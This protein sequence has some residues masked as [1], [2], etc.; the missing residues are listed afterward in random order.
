MVAGDADFP[1]TSLV[2]LG[3]G[4]LS[5]ILSIKPKPMPTVTYPTS[6]YNSFKF[7]EREKATPRWVNNP[8]GVRRRNIFNNSFEC[9]IYQDLR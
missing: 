8:S 2:S 6:F 1:E 7:T 5:I 4:C 9:A 3:F